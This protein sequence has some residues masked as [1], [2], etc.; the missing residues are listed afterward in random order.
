M[1]RPAATAALVL[2][3]GAAA[4]LYQ[5]KHKV[6]ALEA[7]EARLARS[8]AAERQA[9]R[10]LASEW[11]YLNAPRRLAGIAERHLDVA[12]LDARAAL[13]PGELPRRPQGA[14]PAREVDG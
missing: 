5:L 8:I 7:E 1:I 11:A 13:A 12:P 6:A 10:V 3:A 2:V 4:G 14:A 9:I